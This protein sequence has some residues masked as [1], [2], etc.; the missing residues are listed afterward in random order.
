MNG[1]HT[2]GGG[3]HR[4]YL[5]VNQAWLLMWGDPTT[6]PLEWSR[7]AG[8]FSDRRDCD[9]RAKDILRSAGALEV[10]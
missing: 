9:D 8:P 7:I 6:G 5:P 1:V 3:L 10:N 4:V 2:Y